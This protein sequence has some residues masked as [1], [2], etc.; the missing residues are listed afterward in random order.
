MEQRSAAESK[1][2]E[3][4]SFFEIGRTYHLDRVLGWWL[5]VLRNARNS[6]SLNELCAA[7]SAFRL[8][9]ADFICPQF[10]RYRKLQG[11]HSLIASCYLYND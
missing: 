7:I 8:V 5:L 1:A 10:F 9:L 3:A 4:P 2:V 11:Q 6:R